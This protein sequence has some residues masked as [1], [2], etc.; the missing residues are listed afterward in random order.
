[1]RGLRHRKGLEE[2]QFYSLHRICFILTNGQINV[3]NVT[4]LFIASL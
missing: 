1:M 4:I 3:T 2:S